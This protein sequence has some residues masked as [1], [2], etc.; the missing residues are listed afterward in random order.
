MLIE[1]RNRSINQPAH[2]WRL[3][4]DYFLYSST[5]TIYVGNLISLTNFSKSELVVLWLHSFEFL[6]R[7]AVYE[8]TACVCSAKGKSV[9]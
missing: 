5:S 1:I 8:F 6:T 9:L 7:W 3:M 2:P 4:Q